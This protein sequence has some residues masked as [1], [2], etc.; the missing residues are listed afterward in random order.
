MGFRIGCSVKMTGE[1]IAK[2]DKDPI[3]MICLG[4]FLVA[5]VIVIG[6]TVANDFF[7]GGDET[8]SSGDKVSVDYTGTYYDYYGNEL[9][10]VFDTSKSSIGD[11]DDIAKSNDYNRTTYQ[12]LSF[13]IGDGQM[14]KGFENAV[15]G[16]KV[17]DQ[18]E[19]MLDAS[20]GYVGAITKGVLK[21]DG[22]TMSVTTVV[23]K[24]TF[25]KAYPD[26]KLS[27]SAVSF[28]SKYGWDA[29]ASYT[30]NQAGVLIT[31]LPKAGQSYEAYK[32]GD[33]TVNYK[34]TDVSNGN[35]TYSID[36]KNYVKVGGDKIQMIK[37]DL[38]TE[39]IYITNINSQEITYKTGAER[40]NEPL[41]FTIKLLSIN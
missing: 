3:F 39:T 38:G 26:V 27:D 17:G 23:S 41:F 10:V 34:V 24:D 1:S 21:V 37:L 33:T 14:L 32:S 29:Q 22:N 5:A 18:I 15:I 12:S 2:K 19:V 28:T 16:H 11:D 30:F 40:V 25:T 20:E 35:I 9:A 36:I 31:Y 7:P 13:T 6:C 4:I 8:A